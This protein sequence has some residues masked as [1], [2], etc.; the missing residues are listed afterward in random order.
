MRSKLTLNLDDLSVD[1][2]DT[3]MTHKEK[4]TVFGEQC[5]CYTNCTCPGCPSCGATCPAT[6]AN[7]CDDYTCANTCANTCDD[8]TC[9][10]TCDCGGGDPPTCLQTNCGQYFCCA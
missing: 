4:G 9:A 1:S 3:T 6:C 7:T 2:F 5:T 8:Y 10:Y